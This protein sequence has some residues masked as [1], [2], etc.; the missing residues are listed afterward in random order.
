MALE[1]E[2]SLATS[3]PIIEESREALG[4]EFGVSDEALPACEAVI[5]QAARTVQ[6]AVQPD[7]VKADPDVSKIVECAVTAGSDYIVTDGK[8]LLHMG[9]YDA[10]QIVTVSDF[11][12]RG[13]AR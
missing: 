5:R 4:R 9:I 3:E 6:P 1:G 12:A 13:W 7:L 11:L 10:I 8:H 2:I